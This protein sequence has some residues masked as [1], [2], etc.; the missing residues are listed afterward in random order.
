MDELQLS[1]RRG[2]LPVDEVEAR[3]EHVRRGIFR[4]PGEELNLQGLGTVVI[5]H[6]K[7]VLPRGISQGC[8]AA[9]PEVAV[10]LAQQPPASLPESKLGLDFVQT[11]LHL[12]VGASVVDHHELQM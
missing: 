4:G 12:W 11:L 3:G 9:P 5:V 10:G 1:G 8:V 2:L 7:D 6:E